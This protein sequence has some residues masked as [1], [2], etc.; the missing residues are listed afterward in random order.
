MTT[1]TSK[2]I[3]IPGL[4]KH[5]A[6]GRA[7]VRLNGKDHY[8]GVYGTKEA[9]SE[10]KRLISK[11]LNSRTSETKFIPTTHQTNFY[12][13]TINEL[14][15]HYMNH[16]NDYYKNSPSEIKKIVL[17]L[18]PLREEY[19]KSLVHE[20]GPKKL[21]DL[22]LKMT[23]PRIRT[24][25][26]KDE[27]GKSIKITEEK[28]LS[29]RTINQRITIIVRLF[30]WGNAEEIIPPEYPIGAALK[31]IKP[32]KNGRLGVKPPKTIHPA[33]IDD[34]N[35]ATQYMSKPTRAIMELIRLTGMRSNDAC[36]MRPMDIDKSSDV[37]VYEPVKFK[38]SDMTGQPQ[39][40]IYLGKNCQEILKPFLENRPSTSY[41]FSPKE[42]MEDKRAQLRLKRKTKVQPSHYDRRKKDPERQPGL[43][44]SSASL[45]SAVRNA[46]KKAGIPEITPTMVR[47]LFATIVREKYGIENAIKIMGHKHVNTTEIYANFNIN[48]CIE[49]MR[50]IG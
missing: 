29:Q 19:G 12:G 1:P 13:L 40:K 11:W 8:C 21:K 7:V 23:Y 4:C 2:S 42:A 20:F 41:L 45:Y 39:R 30:S 6:S 26:I 31:L 47:H 37:W 24:K 50:E 28:V 18:K 9:N 38:R 25:T 10:Y 32:I 48:K 22:R 3:K 46:A 17:A 5:K 33:K 49:I 14:I 15:L 44:Y 34:F 27:N 36:I 35:K 43:K 16:A